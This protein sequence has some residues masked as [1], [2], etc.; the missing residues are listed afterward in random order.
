MDSVMNQPGYYD[1][2]WNDNLGVDFFI[3]GSINNQP[4]TINNTSSN[5]QILTQPMDP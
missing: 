4:L 3:P 1:I 2:L 5:I